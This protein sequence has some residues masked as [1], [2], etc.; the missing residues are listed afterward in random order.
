MRFRSLV[1]LV[2]WFASSCAFAG[3]QKKIDVSD[4]T[5]SSLDDALNS[6]RS[7]HFYFDYPGMATGPGGQYFFQQWNRGIWSM[8]LEVRGSEDVNAI[9][10]QMSSAPF[11][12]DL[13]TKQR[14]AD[15][16]GGVRVVIQVA[17]AQQHLYYV[18][19]CEFLDGSGLTTQ[20]ITPRL[21]EI[22]SA[23][24]LKICPSKSIQ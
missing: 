15:F 23:S 18:N 13:S 9:I 24:P 6:S 21:I 11:A 16:L 17:G 8:H 3:G 22:L 10:S 7:V 14:K 5:S 4:V 20:A 12:K 1:L 19:G 2:V